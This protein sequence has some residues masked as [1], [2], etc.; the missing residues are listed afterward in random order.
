MWPVALREAGL[1][2]SPRLSETPPGPD[3]STLVDVLLDLRQIPDAAGETVLDSVEAARIRVCGFVARKGLWRCPL[4]PPEFL[5]PGLWHL[6]ADIDPAT[7]PV[8]WHPKRAQLRKLLPIDPLDK[9]ARFLIRRLEKAPGQRLDR[10]ELKR[11]FWRRGA[12]FVDFTID[13]LLAEDHIT[14]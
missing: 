13:R 2:N 11:T 12:R 8:V 9:F 10:R 4:I 14:A 7:R 1:R 3:F 6:A 5:L